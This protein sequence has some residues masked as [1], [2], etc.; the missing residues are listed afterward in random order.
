[1][2]KFFSLLAM[3]LLMAG[4]K[5]QAQKEVYAVVSGKT[6]TLQY[7]STKPTGGLLVSEWT[8]QTTYHATIHDIVETVVF[9]KTMDDAMPTNTSYWFAN[10]IALKQIK[11]IQYLH[12]DD[13]TDMSFMFFKCGLLESIDLSGFNTEK[14]KD[15]QCLFY[16]CVSLKELDL[17]SFNTESTQ[18]MFSMFCGCS[19][20]K[21]LDL[22]HFKTPVLISMPY[23][24]ENCTSLEEVDLSCFSTEKVQGMKE[25]FCGCPQLRTIYCT[26]DWGVN[27]VVAL[28]DKAD[29]FKG[30]TSLVGGKNSTYDKT[31]VDVTFARVDGVGDNKGYFTAPKE[32]YTEFAES[33]GVLTY[34]Y[35][36]QRLYSANKTEVYDPTQS[37]FSGYNDKVL[38]AVIDPSMKDANLTT[39]RMMFYG[40]S[41]SVLSKMTAISGLENLNTEN[42][43]SMEYM[44]YQ[45][46]ALES[47]NLSGFKTANVTSMYGMF[48]DCEKLKELDLRSFNTS[49]VETMNYMFSNCSELEKVDVSSFDT[50]KVARMAAMFNNCVALKEVDL[51]SFDTP[52]LVSMGFIFN[53]CSSLKTLDLSMFNTSKVTNM[54]SLFKDCTALQKVD[55]SGFNTKEATDLEQAFYGCSLLKTIICSGDWNANNNISNP[56][57]KKNLFYGCT[58]LEGGNKTPYSESYVDIDYARVDGKGGNKGYFTP[59]K[60]VYVEFDNS[61]KVMTYRY[62]DNCYYS[63]KTTE[64]YDPDKYMFAAYYDQVEKAVIDPSMAEAKLT[65]LKYMFFGG[66]SNKLSNMQVI[67]GLENLHTENVNNMYNMFAYCAAL[68]EL[69]LSTFKTANVTN[70]RNMFNGCEKLET[71]NVSGFDTKNVSDMS[72][73]FNNCVA[74]KELDL[75]S[76]NTAQVGDMERMFY[77]CSE[78][79]ELDLSS[80]NT[81][82]VTDMSAMFQGC[83]KLEKLDLSSFNTYSVSD[84]DCMFCNCKQIKVLNLNSFNLDNVTSTES[85]FDGCAALTTIYCTDVWNAPAISTNMFNGC[86]ELVG[87]NQTPYSTIHKDKEYARLD[88]L[89]GLPGY[90]TNTAEVYTEY[91]GAGVLTYRYDDQ[92]LKSYKKAE[93]YDCAKKRFEDYHNDITKVIIDASMKDANLKTTAAMFNG[94]ISSYGYGLENLETIEGWEN[95][96]TENVVDMNSMFSECETLTELDLSRLK[97]AKVTDMAYMFDMCS[98]LKKVDI[99][100]FQTDNLVYAGFMFRYCSKL[101]TI[102]HNGDWTELDLNSPDM[103]NGCEKL[104]G[105]KGSKYDSSKPVDNTY[106]RLDGGKDK[107]GYFSGVYTVTLEAENGSANVNE[108]GVNLNHVLEGTKLTFSATPNEG[109][110]FDGWTNYDSGSSLTVTDNVTVTA[111]FKL[112]TF[113]VTFYDWN[114]TVLKTET[115]EYGK[116]ATAPENPVREGYEFVGWDPDFS[117]VKSN[118]T[119]RAQYKSTEGIENVDVEDNPQKIVRDGQ[120]YILVGEKMYDVS[121]QRVK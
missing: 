62:D 20:L 3:I 5:A 114:N 91:D 51:S 44:F 34:R 7:V 97:T 14:V 82:Y 89:G 12:T 66:G 19:K 9:D 67:E 10:F 70:M 31:E 22:S 104:A 45:C 98:K 23:M 85:M 69:N 76:F 79:T 86:A 109:Y 38:T 37:R 72:Y 73:M 119:V 107:P 63:T 60:E 106:A 64:L 101:T 65:T 29:V 75:R 121:G 87:G 68:K 11:N 115:V 110:E 57:Y 103:F 111:N 40:G 71:L 95:L 88:G 54:A 28:S 74:L 36:D 24:F 84:M 18:H 17:S 94:S 26:K 6:M 53:H 33:E 27:S 58:A 35:D 30:C 120:I 46:K 16:Y 112:Q 92:R 83:E 41:G 55:L 8:D 105:R 118:L 39:M 52:D 96:K 78:L 15:F 50:R 93:K 81:S 90:F 48:A 77:G 2:K 4:F 43:T 61:T 59:A 32:V 99:S 100:S 108:S 116:A 56:T 117:N 42:V 1:M 21:K 80:F 102:Y 49:N 13:V 47:L 25:V 113:T